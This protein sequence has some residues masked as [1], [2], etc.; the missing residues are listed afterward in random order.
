MIKR[1]LLITALALAMVLPSARAQ[2][3][4]STIKIA[5]VDL[6]RLLVESDMGKASQQKLTEYFEAKQIELQQEYQALQREGASLENQRSVLSV[7]AYT[8]KRNQLE[9]KTLAFRQKSEQAEREFKEMQEQETQTFLRRTAPIVEEIGKN[10]D[11][12]LILRRTAPAVL[13]FDTAID[14]TSEVLT[15]LN[16]LGPET[17]Q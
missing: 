13:Y 4:G 16:A 3:E 8:A 11:Y 6:N 1:V 9:Q 14:I 2:G 17:Q 15:R 12:T 5:I 10:G 7:D